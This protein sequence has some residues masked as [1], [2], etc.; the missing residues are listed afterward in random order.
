VSADEDGCSAANRIPKPR[1]ASWRS[2]H[3]SARSP[4]AEKVVDEEYFNV[5]PDGSRMIVR[6]SSS[7]VYDDEGVLVAGVL[8]I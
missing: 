2:G 3:W 6:C 1:E 8:V 4:P 5:L 7:P